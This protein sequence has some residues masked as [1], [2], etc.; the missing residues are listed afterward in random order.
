M[1]LLICLKNKKKSKAMQNFK[2][3]KENMNT[4]KSSHNSKTLSEIFQD[5]ELLSRISEESYKRM[6]I[7]IERTS[8]VRHEHD[9]IIFRKP[10]AKDVKTRQL[11][12]EDIANVYQSLE[13]IID[14]DKEYINPLA[15]KQ[16][17][18]MS[19]EFQ[20]IV[21]P[22]RSSSAEPSTH[23]SPSTEEN[24]QLAANEP[25]NNSNNNN[26]N[27][28]NNNSIDNNSNN[29]LALPAYPNT[30]TSVNNEQQEP[31]RSELDKIFEQTSNLM[32][33]SPLET[34]GS[35]H[36]HTYLPRQFEPSAL[37]YVKEDYIPTKEN[38]KEWTAAS[39]DTLI[40]FTIFNA[41]NPH[42]K[43]QEIEILGSQFL[44]DLRDSIYCLSDFTSNQDRENKSSTGKILNTIHKKLSPSIIY[45]DHVFYVDTR[46]PHSKSSTTDTGTSEDYYDERITNW[47]AKKEVNTDIFTY[48]KKEM[49]DTLIESIR[50]KMRKPIAWIHQD[51]CEHL[52]RVKDIRLLS[53]NEYKSK[54]EFPRTTHN[55]KY[56]RF[57]CS[58]CTV[59]PATK[60]VYNDVTTGFSTCYFCDICFESFHYGDTNVEAFD[61]NGTP[62]GYTKL[63][64]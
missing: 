21:F 17:K 52:I 15:P 19:E 47:L 1:I 36:L 29:N 35:K 55:V 6:R 23:Q 8:R 22:S 50:F 16:R 10:Q 59:Y 7:K 48:E 9:L 64:K 28:N 34:V 2:S 46:H 49:Q 11:V 18:Y 62:G 41:Y 54:D 61:Y 44:S 43:F 57:K 38:L 39:Q 4:S 26:N 56:D 3:R 33:Q 60:V 63:M 31:E 32:S 5:P 20:D 51:S 27:N 12:T 13:E 30:V 40:T 25:I 53:P 14:N 58:L 37:R 24:S 42:I 45:M